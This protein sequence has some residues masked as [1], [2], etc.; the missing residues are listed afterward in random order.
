MRGS[1]GSHDCWGVCV[2]DM[3]GEGCGGVWRS[4]TA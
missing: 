3:A 4:G 2:G 1:V